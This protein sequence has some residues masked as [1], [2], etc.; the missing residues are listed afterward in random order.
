MFLHMETLRVLRNA[1]RFAQ[2]GLPQE[3][4]SVHIRMLNFNKRTLHTNSFVLTPAREGVHHLNVQ[5][6]TFANPHAT[7][8]KM[9]IAR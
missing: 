6:K 9:N 7:L 5:S 4:G 3:V 8:L 2:C 1:E